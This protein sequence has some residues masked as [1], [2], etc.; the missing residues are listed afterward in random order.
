MN[1]FLTVLKKIPGMSLIAGIYR[2]FKFFKRAVRLRKNLAEIDS[3]MPFDGPL[4]S[5]GY[6][7]FSLSDQVIK[8]LKNKAVKND[9]AAANAIGI[10]PH[11]QVE[12]R[13]A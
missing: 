10:V 13:A 8:S 12:Y 2:G 7:M 5:L 11:V 6:D 3:K 9:I 4:G 1:G